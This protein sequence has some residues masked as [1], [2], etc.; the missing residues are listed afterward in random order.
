LSVPDL[1]A[2][3]ARL[4]RDQLAAALAAIAAR[5]MEVPRAPDPAPEADELLTVEQTAKLLG[6]SKSWLYHAKDLPFAVRGIGSAP[7][8]SRLG[9]EKYIAK[10]RRA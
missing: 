9:L 7:R 10:R 6:K 3:I 2:E 1:I 8:F 4:D 5:L